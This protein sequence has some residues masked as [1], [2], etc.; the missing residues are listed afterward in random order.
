MSTFILVLHD[1]EIRYE[2]AMEAA[3]ICKQ[4]CPTIL[5]DRYIL[6]SKWMTQE[7]SLCT[8][9]WPLKEPKESG[10]C[11]SVDSVSSDQIYHILE[12][13]RNKDHLKKRQKQGVVQL[14]HLK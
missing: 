7:M 14:Y 3:L 9:R 12:V 11:S 10:S 4:C 1:E 5:M 13:I 6:L 8:R 2:V